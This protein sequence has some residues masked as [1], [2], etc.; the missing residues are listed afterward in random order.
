MVNVMNVAT[1]YDYLHFFLNCSTTIIT[2]ATIK[3]HA[4]LPRNPMI[5]PAVLNIKLAIEPII[6]VSPNYFP[7][8]F[9]PFSKPLPKVVKPFFRSEAITSM[10]T[11]TAERTANTVKP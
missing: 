2:T 3:S 5:S 7:I 4:F 11:P 1:I 8:P 10:T 9:N 6:P